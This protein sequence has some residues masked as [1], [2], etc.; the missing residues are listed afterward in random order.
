MV[1]ADEAARERHAAL[2]CFE[3]DAGACHRAVVAERLVARTGYSI[4]DL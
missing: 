2:L 3:A 4:V 1:Q